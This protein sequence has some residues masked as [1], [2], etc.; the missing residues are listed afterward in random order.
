[1]LFALQQQLTIGDICVHH[2]EDIKRWQASLV[3]LPA[4]KLQTNNGKHEDG[5]E[6]QKADLEQRDHGF[7]DGLQYNLQA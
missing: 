5:E 4:V 1:M 6:Q 3:K 2:T 7:H